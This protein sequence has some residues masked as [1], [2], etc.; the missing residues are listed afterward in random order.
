MQQT[1]KEKQLHKSLSI[2][3]CTDGLSFCSYSPRGEEHFVY[4]IYKVRPTKS[5]AANLKE[6]LMSEPM[7]QEEYARVNVLVTTPQFTTVPVVDFDSD[8][9]KS[10]FEYNF[11]KTEPLRIS[12]NL[13]RRSGIA[14]IFGL[15]KNVYKLITDDF[16]RSRFYASASTLIEFF[17]EKSMVGSNK[18]M[19]VYL[20]EKEMTLYCFDQGRLLFVN[21]YPV[22]YISDCQYYIL[23][24]WKHLGFDQLD[25]ALFVV[26]DKEQSKE[27]VS[28]LS[29]FLENASLLDRREDFRWRITQ[30]ES[31]IPYDLHTL[32]V[33]GF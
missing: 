27:L 33:C 12:Y 7:L 28:K 8:S 1:D 6:A 16:P 3:V 32:L 25:D 9:I 31:S 2:R 19:F 22:Y 10:L 5:L 14:I 29:Y 11:P 17:S 30:G 26:S 23:N 15:D 18:K 4:N 20:H 13:L 24:V 21:T